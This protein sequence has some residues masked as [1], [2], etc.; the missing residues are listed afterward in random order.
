[1]KIGN[2]SGVVRLIPA[3]LI[4]LAPL[5]LQKI[6]WPAIRLTFG[7]YSILQAS[8]VFGSAARHQG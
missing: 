8:S 3:T 5:I 4:P 6:F 1:M 2:A 7:F